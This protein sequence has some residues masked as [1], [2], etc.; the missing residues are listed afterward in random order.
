MARYKIDRYVDAE[1]RCK[2]TLFFLKHRCTYIKGV[3]WRCKYCLEPMLRIR[4]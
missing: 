2:H 3:G 4:K 1:S